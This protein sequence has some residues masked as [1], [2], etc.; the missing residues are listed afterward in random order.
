MI[1]Q[2][3][4]FST[5][6]LEGTVT[7]V[8]WQARV[9]LAACYRLAAHYRMSDQI[10]THISARVPGTE[11]LL[12][13]PY[14]TLFDEVRASLLVKVDLEGQV[15][16][17]A[18]G[19]G[20]N[21]AGFVIHSAIHGALDDA[22]CVMHTHTRAGIAVAAQRGGLRPI[23]Q[24][25]MRFH[26]ALAYHDYEGVA[27][28]LDERA[29]L[30]ADLG[31]HRAMILRHHGLLTVGRTVREAFERMYFLELACQIQ[32]DAQ[33]MGDMVEAPEAV[34]R[35]VAAQ[36]SNPGRTPVE[37]RDWPALLRLLARTGADYR[38]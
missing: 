28:D 17:D 35:K 2:P 36:F 18:T 34:A 10:Y 1:A 33:A 32:T 21:R 9:Q 4:D 11:H 12:L 20:I 16:Q 13:N 25:A 3:Q 15:L 31:A 29:R 26:G 37:D 5:V 38:T 6:T 8:E 23:S 30:V 7:S 19:L 22:G 24:H 14:G 27:L